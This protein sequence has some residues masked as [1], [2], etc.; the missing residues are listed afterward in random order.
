MYIYVYKNDEKDLIPRMDEK[1]QS[2]M[3][4]DNLI[5]LQKKNKSFLNI[6]G[7]YVPLKN[8]DVLVL[9]KAL[10]EQRQVVF[11]NVKNRLRP[12][13]TEL[14]KQIN[15]SEVEIAN[16]IKMIAKLTK[17]VEQEISE[18]NALLDVSD[19]S[20][21]KQQI[22]TEM[23]K[24]LRSDVKDEDVEIFI[25]NLKSKQYKFSECQTGRYRW[26]QIPEISI[27]PF[28]DVELSLTNRV[29]HLKTL[30][31]Y[32]DT[33][34]PA[35][36]ME[37]DTNNSFFRIA[38]AKVLEGQRLEFNWYTSPYVNCGMNKSFDFKEV[39]KRLNS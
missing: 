36:E 3:W 20:L 16:R 9:S 13:I 17:L 33:D 35:I 25:K 28:G 37:Y 6:E 32:L 22:T 23:Q 34:R 5:E 30:V 11:K 4:S 24:V 31:R 19:N 14:S 29:G 7:Y 10:K 38:N 39:L 2:Y 15:A 26:K 21:D 8:D 1:K 27:S 12:V 18:L